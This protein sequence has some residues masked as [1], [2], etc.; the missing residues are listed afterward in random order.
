M[1]VQKLS[2]KEFL[3]GP[4]ATNDIL[5]DEAFERNL[6]DIIAEALSLREDKFVISDMPFGILND[7]YVIVPIEYGNFVF[8]NNSKNITDVYQWLKDIQA[9]IIKPKIPDCIIG[10]YIKN[11]IAVLK[12]HQGKGIG[13]ELVVAKYKATGS[14]PNWKAW[15]PS[16]T[17]A[18][19]ATHKKAYQVAIERGYIQA[20]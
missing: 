1:S 9:S 17:P 6:S 20:N 8:P 4:N 16:Y 13:K 2:E 7:Q 10:C 18:G 3:C 14:L 15:R 5:I 19:L 11:D 12:E